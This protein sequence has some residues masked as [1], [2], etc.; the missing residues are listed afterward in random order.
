MLALLFLSVNQSHQVGLSNFLIWYKGSSY[1]GLRWV[2]LTYFQGQRSNCI[3]IT[4]DQ[5]QCP[6]LQLHCGATESAGKISASG[7]VWARE[8]IRFQIEYTDNESNF[9]LPLGDLNLLLKIKKSN[10]A[11]ITFWQWKLKVM[12]KASTVSQI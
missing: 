9:S 7:Q 11:Q 12:H 5:A 3:T 6:L 1:K 2:V 10:L 8:H 4:L